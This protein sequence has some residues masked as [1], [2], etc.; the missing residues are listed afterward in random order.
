MLELV[1]PAP[2]PGVCPD[3]FNFT[4]VP[5][6]R[7]RAC[8]ASESQLAAMVPISYAEAGGELHRALADYKRAAEPAVPYLTAELARMLSSF[9]SEHEGCVARAAGV[10]SFDCVVVVPSTHHHGDVVHPLTQIVARR[11]EETAGRHRDVLVVSGRRCTP[12]AFDPRRFTPT[13][14]LD[15][16]NVLLIDDM[17]TTGANAQSAAA[18]LHRAGA[19]C[20]AAVVIGRYVNGYWG[21]IAERLAGLRARARTGACALCAT[22]VATTPSEPCPAGTA[23]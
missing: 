21:G 14:R 20:V 17:W 22:A 5:S 23:A 10:G 4:L 2:G 18:A 13:R 15:G 19:R 8:A 11:V 3:C 9:L 7:C 16:Q 12:H 6:G 1:T